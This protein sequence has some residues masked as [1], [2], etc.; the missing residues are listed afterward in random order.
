MESLGVCIQLAGI[1]EWCAWLG[2]AVVAG[3]R[4]CSRVLFAMP[5][6]VAWWR[7]LFLIA[8]L[9]IGVLGNLEGRFRLS[10]CLWLSFI[11]EGILESAMSLIK[12]LLN[13]VMDPE[14]LRW[15][16]RLEKMLGTQKGNGLARLGFEI[17]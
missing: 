6:Q 3:E 17:S 9:P 11:S 4:V 13:F 16:W 8:L 14:A 1:G 10:L 5:P 2:V 15:M 7:P 12:G